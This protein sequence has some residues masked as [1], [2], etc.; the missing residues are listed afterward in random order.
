M[1]ALGAAAPFAGRFSMGVVSAEAMVTL[2][3]ALIAVA[4]DTC[5]RT[6]DDVGLTLGKERTPS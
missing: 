3:Q 4:I 2:T 6:C 5:T 1:P